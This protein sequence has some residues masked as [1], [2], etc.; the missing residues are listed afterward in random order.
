MQTFS[1]FPRFRS[2]VMATDEQLASAIPDPT[3]SIHC[4]VWK[5][6][7]TAVVHNTIKMA[8]FTALTAAVV[9]SPNTFA[10]QS[11]VT[12]LNASGTGFA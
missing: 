4:V 2:C 7:A 9:L 5:D 3:S 6:P 10:P 8:C 1:Y 12:M 11:S